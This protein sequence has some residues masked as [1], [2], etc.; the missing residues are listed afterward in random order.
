MSSGER[1][2]NLRQMQ[3][4]WVSNKCWSDFSLRVLLTSSL[5]LISY[6]FSLLFLGEFDKG[7][8]LFER[9]LAISEETG[10]RD[11]LTVYCLQC[12]ADTYL[13]VWAELP[14]FKKRTRQKRNTYTGI[15]V[16]MGWERVETKYGFCD[17]KPESLFALTQAMYDKVKLLVKRS[18]AILSQRLGSWN[19][20]IANC[21]I[22][23]AEV[24]LHEARTARSLPS[25]IHLMS[26]RTV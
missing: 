4:K 8:P 26:S 12:L 11:G 9:S 2:A 20:Y 7:L 19:P 18:F 16:F 22:D 10:D 3:M 15:F 23:A 1:L 13:K 14:V 24:S 6:F 5:D 17:A 21:L 25:L